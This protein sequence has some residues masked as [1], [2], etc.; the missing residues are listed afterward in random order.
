[1]PLVPL[2]GPL[3]VKWLLKALPGRLAQTWAPRI[4]GAVA[5]VIVAG[6]LWLGLKLAVGA[7]REDARNDLLVEQAAERAAAADAQR[8]R[9]YHVAARRVAEIKAGAATDAK[10]QEELTNATQNLPDTRP[11]AR[12]RSRVCVEL[13]QQ[14]RAAGRPARSC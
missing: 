8:E 1:M 14:D 7:I 13:Q 2:L 10:Q 4:G 5:L 11:T 6:L 3:L 9:E 12:Q